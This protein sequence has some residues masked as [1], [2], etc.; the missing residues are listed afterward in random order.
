MHRPLLNRPL[1][2]LLAVACGSICLTGC[3]PGAVPEA[4]QA[5]VNQGSDEPF[6]Y[7]EVELSDPT[8]KIDP[9]GVCWFEVHYK[10]VKGKVG[11]NYLLNLNFPGTENACIKQMNGW[12]LSGPEGVIK[13]GIQL[14]DREISEYEFV[15][16]EAEVPMDGFT[17]IS[18]VLKG[19]IEDSA[20]AL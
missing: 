17:K 8:F 19:K 4:T 10:F 16:S 12:Q 6:E 18:N 1:K 5:V 13:D 7:A 15:F 9:D 14:I 11:E 3:Q 2:L 20:T